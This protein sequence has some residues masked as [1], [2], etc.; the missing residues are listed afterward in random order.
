MGSGTPAI[1][2][3]VVA[4]PAVAFRTAPADK[5]PLRRPYADNFA[6]RNFKPRN[7]GELMHLDAHGVAGVAVTLHHFIMPDGSP[8]RMVERG[9]Y[10]EP[11]P[12]GHIHR[13]HHAPQ[14][15]P[16]DH[17]AVDAHQPVVLCA[18]S[19]AGNRGVSVRQREMPAL[20]E[21]QFPVQFFGEAFVEA[22][23]RVVE[24]DAGKGAVVGAQNR[25][26]AGAVSAPDIALLQ[27]RYFANAVDLAQVISRGEPMNARADDG[28]I[29]GGLEGMPAPH[30]RPQAYAFS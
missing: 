18:Y 13:R 15:V 4:H 24:S 3:M 14:F 11:R 26:V 7:R 1:S 25:R 17:A 22:K 19:Q 28:H 10:G 23:R 16:V 5:S 8:G 30:D 27:Q 9:E 29:V 21:I 2:E 20:V 6:A 12:V